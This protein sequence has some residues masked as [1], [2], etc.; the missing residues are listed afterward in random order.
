[1]RGVLKALV[2]M[3][4]QL[5][6][7]LFLSLGSSDGGKNEINVLFSTRLVSNDTIVVEVTNNR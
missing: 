7:D 2:T 6:G 3:E 1:M 4:L 5:R